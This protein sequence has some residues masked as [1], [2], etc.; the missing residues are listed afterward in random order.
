MVEAL[1]VYAY[2]RALRYEGV[3][4][5]HLDEPEYRRALTLARKYAEHLHV[6]SGIPAVTVENGDTTVELCTYC[7]GYLLAF[8]GEYHELDRLASYVHYVVE[9]E[10]F[11]H[12]CAKS[13]H[14]SV[15]SAY[16]VAKLWEEH[17]APDDAQVD[18]K[19]HLAQR[20]V[21]VFVYRCGYYVGAARGTVVQEDYGK[22]RACQHTS[23]E[24]R[25]EVL[26][27]S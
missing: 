26:V 17:T 6:L 12:H 14:H 11:H 4:V 8:L 18:G 2:Y 23:Y 10:V 13:E 25:H 22:C 1:T 7:V 15:D 5:Y 20:E 9:H 3:R 16:G 27:I 19:Q 24:Q 21:V